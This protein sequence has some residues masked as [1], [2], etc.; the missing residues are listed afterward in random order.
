MS[1][2][3][4]SITSTTVGS[5]VGTTIVLNT[6][7]IEPPSS[8]RAFVQDQNKLD[9]EKLMPYLFMLARGIHEDVPNMVD[10]TEVEPFKKALD[11]NVL[12]KKPISLSKQIVIQELRRRKAFKKLNA[13]NKKIE[14]LFEMLNETV[15]GENDKQFVK[16]SVTEYL[17]QISTAVKE[18]EER[19]KASGGR[20]EVTDRLRWIIAIDVCGDIREAYL[21]LQDVLSR[22]QLDGRNSDNAAMDFHDLITVKFNDDS[23]VP[24]TNPIPDL[25]SFFANSISCRK[26]EYYSLTREKSKH[27]LLDYKHKLNEICKRYEMS[28]NGVGQLDS[29]D[30]EEDLVDERQF[31]RVNLELARLKGGDDRQNF[32]KHESFDLLYFWDVMDRHDLI[33]FTTAQLRGPNAATSEQQP[34]ETSYQSPSMDSYDVSRGHSA[35]RAKHDDI[36]SKMA[37][38]VSRVGNAIDKMN[39]QSI[40]IEINSLKKEKNKLKNEW[41]KE[42]K[43]IDYESDEDGT[44]YKEAIAD[45]DESIKASKNYLDTL[46]N[47]NH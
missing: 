12:K 14:E 27:M 30:E 13:N 4:S 39:E 28:G 47:K 41:R 22:E 2:T 34:A 26:R 24:E 11:L 35:K 25:H 19:K 18:A 6:S 43:T 23:W 10:L 38:N 21:K 36:S 44:F 32:L 33:H 46:R 1:S 8:V 5:N 29:D 42:R 15:L 45:I 16:E 17:T 20:A 37:N 40:M 3:S 31:G 7:D 9:A